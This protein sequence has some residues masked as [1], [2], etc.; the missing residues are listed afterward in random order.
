M[1]NV[2]SLI[3]LDLGINHTKRDTYFYTLI[4]S[5]RKELTH[6]GIAIDANSQE[7]VML[8]VDYCLWRY[9]H[10]AVDAT[11]ARNISDR[12]RQRIMRRRANA[13]I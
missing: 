10:R 9:R 4:E 13:D 12:I 6:Y 11:L 8:L 2:L 5:C 1:D 7:D 3:K